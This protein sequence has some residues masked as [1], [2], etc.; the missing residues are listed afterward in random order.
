MT[1]DVM[2][3]ESQVS[4]C[5][6]EVGFQLSNVESNQ[7]ITVFHTRVTLNFTH[8]TMKN[9]DPRVLVDHVEMLVLATACRCL[10]TVRPMARTVTNSISIEN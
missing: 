9:L 1:H 5:H 3:Q 8:T 6:S 10:D 2:N 4:T 7:E